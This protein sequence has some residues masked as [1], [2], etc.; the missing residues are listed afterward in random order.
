[1]CKTD[2][3]RR[4]RDGAAYIHVAVPLTAHQPSP[5]C[6]A[7]DIRASILGHFC[8]SLQGTAPAALDAEQSCTLVT[9]TAASL[10]KKARTPSAH[11]VGSCSRTSGTRNQ[12]QHRQPR[13]HAQALDRSRT[14]G[15]SSPI[16]NP[17][18]F[19]SCQL[20]TFCPNDAEPRNRTN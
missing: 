19:S 4:R 12:R 7:L 11:A 9:T 13:R 5:S 15:I 14:A 16:G 1:M 8:L 6:Q 18:V 17:A 10:T 3:S 2:D 20:A